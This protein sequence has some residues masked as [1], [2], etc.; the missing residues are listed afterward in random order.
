MRRIDISGEIF[1]KLARSCVLIMTAVVS[2]AACSSGGGNG[3]REYAIPHPLCKIDIDR[4]L[5]QSLFPAGSKV[6]VT[7]YNG[8]MGGGELASTG[9]CIVEVDDALA[10]YIE[11]R[12]VKPPDHPGVE[13]YVQN[14]L[15]RRG[16]L[17]TYQIQEA[18]QVAD[19]P[20]ETWVWPDFAATSTLCE[21]SSIDFTA[22]NV[23]VRL[24][25]VSD[26]DHS[27][28]LEEFIGPFAA[29]QVRRIGE[30]TCTPA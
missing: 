13:A 15:D 26:D 16:N 20:H 6:S 24:D 7:D 1:M 4:S 11:I 18:R 14:Y 29:E 9:E 21:S 17:G 30:R 27:E 5:Y 23:S 3:K 10:I 2:V 28:P 22:I 12:A 25:W 8:D 19:G